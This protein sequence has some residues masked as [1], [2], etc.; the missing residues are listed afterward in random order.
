M[1]C[2]FAKI[3][4]QM[5]TLELKNNLLR[6]I[7]ETDDPVKLQLILEWFGMIREEKDWWLEIS[8]KERQLILEGRKQLSEGKGI[9][10]EEVR[11]KVQNLLKELRQRQNPAKSVA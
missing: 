10:H 1:H 2:I 8:E 4:F 5:S 6:M 7:A 9:P 3:L 11:L